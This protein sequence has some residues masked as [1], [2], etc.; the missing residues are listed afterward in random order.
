M[1]VSSPPQWLKVLI[2][3]DHHQTRELLRLL[4]TLAGYR[5][6][7]TSTV[8][9]AVAHLNSQTHV[10]LDLN[11]LDGS[12]VDVLRSIR[13]GYPNTIVALTT[14]ERDDSPHM[15]SAM[16]HH[17]QAVFQKPLDVNRLLGWLQTQW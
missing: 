14:A 6:I 1:S 5:V 13:T 16:L 15:A 17:P 7:A 2:V 8:H 3:E 9:D 4:L 11:L 10:L 12:G